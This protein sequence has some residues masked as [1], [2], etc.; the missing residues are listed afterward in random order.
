MFTGIIREVA[1][2]KSVSV[3]STGGVIEVYMDQM[4]ERVQPGDSIA[5]DGVCLTATTIGDG[6]VRFDAMPETFSRTTL[7]QLKPGEFVNLEDAVRLGE[8][9]G[10]HIVQGHVDTVGTLCGIVLRGNAHEWRIRVEPS[11][12]RLI[13]PKGSVAVN[14]ISLTV[15]DTGSDWFS[16]GI[17]P[18]TRMMTTWH[19]KRMDDRVNVETDILGRYV[20]RLLGW[21]ESSSVDRDLLARCGFMPT[22]DE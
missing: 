18:H 7:A 22:S 15:I 11:W 9:L 13:V 14:G 12:M 1:P 10:G 17:I 8:P 19:L 3:S 21:R 16:V 20:E 4:L 5:V 6:F 2:V